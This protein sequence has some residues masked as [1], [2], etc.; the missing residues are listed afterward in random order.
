VPRE[1]AL[2]ELARRYLRG[3]GPAGPQDLARWS[4]IGLG[5]ARRALESLGAEFA[6]APDVSRRS[7][8]RL[9]GPFDPVMFGW[10]D[11]RPLLGDHAPALVTSNGLF[12]PAMLAGNRIVGT[13]RVA[14]GRVELHPLESITEV[15]QRAFHREARA[16]EH[17]LAGR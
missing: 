12:R 13:W 8:P 11:R 3:H 2:A 4:G 15:E 9:L 6:A 14:D 7:R 1:H 10:V 17:F 16:V 5:A